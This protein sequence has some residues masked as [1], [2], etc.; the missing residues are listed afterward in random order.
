MKI[1]ITEPFGRRL[2]K[3]KKNYPDTHYR[4]KNYNIFILFKKTI[5]KIVLQ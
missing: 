2:K 3:L 5:Y 4:I 1:I